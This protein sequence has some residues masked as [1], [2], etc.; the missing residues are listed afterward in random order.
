MV[1]RKA[2]DLDRYRDLATKVT[3]EGN[4]EKLSELL[5]HLTMSF[6]LLGR[7]FC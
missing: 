3:K 2:A 7:E 5:L 1:V 6:Y 4:R